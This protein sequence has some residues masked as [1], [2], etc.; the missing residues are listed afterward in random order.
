MALIRMRTQSAALGLLQRLSCC[1]WLG[2]LQVSLLRCNCLSCLVCSHTDVPYAS[3]QCTELGV[4]QGGRHCCSQHSH[5]CTSQRQR[6][7]Q[8]CHLQCTVYF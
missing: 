2:V 4:S 6:A 1:A 3:L 8:P 5:E 7:A